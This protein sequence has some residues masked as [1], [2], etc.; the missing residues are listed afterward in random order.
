[1]V[2]R[3][4]VLALGCWVATC[5]TT[6]A[7]TRPSGAPVSDVVEPVDCR[8]EGEEAGFFFFMR[9]KRRSGISLFGSL[10]CLVLAFCVCLYVCYRERGAWSFQ[11]WSFLAGLDGETRAGSE[12][13]LLLYTRVR[14]GF[15]RGVPG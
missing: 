6:R 14:L 7:S 9:L 3:L 15:G 5:S 11:T 4:E 10:V 1:M 13:T 12:V 8:L 2:E